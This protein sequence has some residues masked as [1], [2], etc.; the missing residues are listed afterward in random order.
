MLRARVD[1]FK[2]AGAKAKGEKKDEKRNYTRC[3][4]PGSTDANPSTAKAEGSGFFKDVNTAALANL[5]SWVPAIFARAKYYP[6]TGAWRIS[7]A[8]LGRELEED[9]SISPKGITDWGVHD[10]GDAHDGG[11]TAI[12]IVMEYGGA[13][14]AVAAA[15]WLCERMGIDPQTLG[16]EDDYDSGGWTFAGSAFDFNDAKPQEDED[17]PADNQATGPPEPPPSDDSQKPY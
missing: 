15:H 9:L 13:P 4:H 14:D 12:D 10:M 1:A 17:E 7:S 2:A 5:S 6:G 11:R 16:W 8:D 3:E